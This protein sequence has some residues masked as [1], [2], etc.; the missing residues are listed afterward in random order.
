MFRIQ[1]GNYCRDD[2]VCTLIQVIQQAD[3]LHAYTVQQL[4][5]CMSADI[6][7][8]PLVQTAVWCIGEYGDLLL[9]NCNDEDEPLNVIIIS[10]DFCCN[11]S[12]RQD[13]SKSNG[14]NLHETL[15]GLLLLTCT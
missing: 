8:Q 2:V 10:L 12:F 9:S 6:S 4:Y 3:T 11:H 5:K 15:Q 7:Q 13:I 1:S 14:Q